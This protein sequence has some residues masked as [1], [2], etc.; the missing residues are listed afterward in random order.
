MTLEQDWLS[1]ARCELDALEPRLLLAVFDTA[2]YFPLGSGAIWGYQ[3]SQTVD[4]GALASGTSVVRTDASETITSTEVT[5][6]R[7]SRTAI[8]PFASRTIDDF[9]GFN[10]AGLRLFRRDDAHDSSSLRYGAGLPLLPVQVEDGRTYTASKFVS[11]TRGDAS[12]TGSISSSSTVVG[13]E[14]ITVSAGTF[15][16]LKISITLNTSATLTESMST[17]PL[18]VSESITLWLIAGIG[19]GREE[20]TTETTADTTQTVVTTRALTGTTLLQQLD[21]VQVLGKNMPIALGDDTPTTLDGTNYGGVDVDAQTKT[22]IFVIRNVSTQTVTL[23]TRSGVDGIVSL[24][25]A[26]A[27]EFTLVRLPE[28]TTI[29][30]GGRVV[31]S[32]RFDPAALGFRSAVVGFSLAGN[33]NAAFS[34]TIRGT[35]LNIGRIDVTREGTTR[36]IPSGAASSVA[37]GTFFGNIAEAGN[38]RS[39][40]TYRITNLG[41]GPLQLT[42]TPRVVISGPAAGDFIVTAQP[43]DMIASDAVSLFVVRFNPTAVGTRTATVTIVSNDPTQSSYSFSISG[44]GI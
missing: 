31:F 10:S 5:R 39:Q 2:E 18:S 15:D 26:S 13:V 21:S 44:N 14:S 30:P 11:G 27:A 1:T 32:V 23:A 40:R 12:V 24:S 20:R 35:G 41:D 7:E 42:G 34:F 9:W 16:A 25:G 29:A 3:V 28:S 43:I 19:I 17:S 6:V 22:R 37:L 38:R 8:T 33:P 4:A 36:S